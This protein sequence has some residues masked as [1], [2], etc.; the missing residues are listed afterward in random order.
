MKTILSLACILGIAQFG[1]AAPV[2]VQGG[3]MRVNEA[4]E[5][6]QYTSSFAQQSVGLARDGSGV[7]A[8]TSEAGDGSGTR[9]VVRPFNLGEM[10]AAAEFQANVTTQGNQG[11]PAVAVRDNGD[12]AV[13]WMGNG[14]D[15]PEGIFMRLFTADGEA[16]TGEIR[17]SVNTN[18]P[19]SFDDRA[20]PSVAISPDGNILVTWSADLQDGG[21]RGVYYRLMSPLG[22]PLTGELRANA[23]TSGHQRRSSAAMASDGSFV[24]A[25]FGAISGGD[26]FDV[27][28]RRFDAAGAPMG[29]DTRANTITAG[30]Q[31]I[32]TLAMS[33][34]GRFVLAWNSPDGEVHARQFSAAGVPATG[35]EFVVNTTVDNL[36]INPVAAMEDDGSYTIVWESDRQDGSG[37]GIFAQSFAADGARI[38]C[39]FRVNST[40]ASAQNGAAIA[41]AG[42]GRRA[43]VAWTSNL[44]DG[45]GRGVYARYFAPPAVEPARQAVCAGASL[46]L[47]VP[48]FES[49]AS[50][51]WMKDGAAIDGAT[52][53]TLTLRDFEPADA[54]YYECEVASACDE[55]SPTRAAG[56]SVFLRLPA[57]VISEPSDVEATAG[58]LLTLTAQGAGIGLTFRWFRD[59]VPLSDDERISGA[60]SSV[61]TISPL[62]ERDAGSFRCEVGNACGA[63]S[64]R[65]AVV[66]V[67]PFGAWIVR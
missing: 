25:W 20:W 38:G 36:Q 58:G 49:G 37:L 32:Q 59:D 31:D 1:T 46:D 33:P 17:V 47:T 35:A 21:L 2:G 39:E 11:L 28:F 12:F 54:G 51:Q 67:R 40:T 29:T 42:D 45:S 62:S 24:I 50:Y 44:Q 56:S 7:F 15:D 10:F 57:A 16:L 53:P 19:S 65:A 30:N 14:P 61:L 26:A 55:T 23:Q 9:V 64:T 63:V 18:R 5:S 13:V 43:V 4:T 52:T 34:D 60:E 22:V 8:F 48:L 66:T 27:V 3:E 6:N 41:T